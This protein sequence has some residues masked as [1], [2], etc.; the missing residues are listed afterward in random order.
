MVWKGHYL[1]AQPSDV[2]MHVPVDEYLAKSADKVRIFGPYHRETL[3]MARNPERVPKP[4]SGSAAVALE[5]FTREKIGVE[6]RSLADAFLL[7]VLNGRLREQVVHFK[8]VG[9]AAAAMAAGRVAAVL[10]PRGELEAAVAGQSGVVLD[11]CRLPELPTDGWPL[12]MAVRVEEDALAQALSDALAD[13]KRD[14][15][16]AAIFT[17]YGITYTPA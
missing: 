14:G 5:V 11:A 6:G 15:S 1:G 8:S 7:G 3:A 16:L 2:M 10:A 4:P 9:E 12:G 17:R 13:L